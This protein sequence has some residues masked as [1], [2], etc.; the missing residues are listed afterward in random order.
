MVPSV[1]GTISADSRISTTAAKTMQQLEDI[2]RINNPPPQQHPPP[3][4]QQ[5]DPVP[6]GNAATAPLLHPPAIVQVIQPPPPVQNQPAQPDTRRVRS[7]NYTTE[8]NMYFLGIMADILPIGPYEWERVVTQHSI[9]FPGR[10]A[11]SLRRKYTSLYRKQIPTGDPNCPEDVKL[12]KRVMRDIGERASLGQPE[13]TFNLTDGTFTNPSSTI[14]SITQTDNQQ[15]PNPPANNLNPS[16]SA[17]TT[18]TNTAAASLPAATSPAGAPSINRTHMP[19]GTVN[20]T[21]GKGTEAASF[22]QLYQMQMLNDMKQRAEDRLERQAQRREDELR[23]EKDSRDFKE[24]FVLAMGGISNG[25][26]NYRKRGRSQS[27]ERD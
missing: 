11:T 10:D 25:L 17:S 13:E 20:G 8:E 22:L 19:R 16:D 4:D 23:R 15:A 2:P 21:P 14:V 27:P 7:Q 1:D 26:A 5:P 24:L 3:Q 6:N 9:A 18:T 12:A